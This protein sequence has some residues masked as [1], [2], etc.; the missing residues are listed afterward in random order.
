MRSSIFKGIERE[1]VNKTLH[2]FWTR[3]DDTLKGFRSKTFP[4]SLTGDPWK[5]LYK[6]LKWYKINNSPP[7]EKGRL[8]GILWKK[9]LDT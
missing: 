7:F 2:Y 9:I 5:R 4:A 1:K 3:L 6:E 8:G